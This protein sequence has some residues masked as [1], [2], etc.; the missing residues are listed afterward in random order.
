MATPTL[1]SLTLPGTLGDLFVDVRAAGRGEARPA[2]VIVHGFKGFKDWGFFPPLAER[3]ARAGFTAVSFNM[4]GSGVDAAGRPTLPERFSRNTYGAELA[5]LAAVIDA[6]ADGRLGAASP[7][8]IG[9]VG[10]SRGGGI[11]VLQAARDRRVRALVT[12][13]AIGDVG[14]WDSRERQEWRARGHLDVVN[15]RTGQVIPLSTAV[16]DEIESAAPELD[17]QG[18]AASITVPWLIIHGTA[19]DAVSVED[20]IRLARASGR[21]STRLVTI[22][23]GNHGFGAGHPWAP[24]VDAPIHQVLDA[25]VEWLAASVR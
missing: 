16:L 12:W 14:R 11:A 2:V 24:P 23:G 7:T 1:T 6:L 8:A 20:A 22:P 10:H 4:S 13:A 21:D 25:T 3:L 19:D 17:I 15:T 5:D 9:L 18:A